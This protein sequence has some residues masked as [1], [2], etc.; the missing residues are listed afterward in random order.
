VQPLSQSQQNLRGKK[1]L[2]M[3]VPQLRDWIAACDAMELWKH[4]SSK[5]RRGWKKSRE[6]AVA[7]LLRRG[8]DGRLG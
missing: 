3:T 2:D 6:E 7:E 5:N 4:I 8:G 1:I